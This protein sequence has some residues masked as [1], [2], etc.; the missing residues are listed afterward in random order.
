MT[1]SYESD[2]IIDVDM[3]LKQKHQRPVEISGT[4]YFYLFGLIPDE[5]IVRLDYD[6]AYEG[7]KEVSGIE[8]EEGPSPVD[9]LV[10]IFSLGLIGRRSYV[11]KG[12]TE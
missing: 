9:S 10:T 3:N 12:Y 11:V 6:F 5:S 1:I 2:S 8:I 4:K 7:Y